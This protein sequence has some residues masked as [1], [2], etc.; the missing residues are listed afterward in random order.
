MKKFLSELP[1]YLALI[2]VVAMIVAIAI[3]G[4]KRYNEYL[5]EFENA[6]SELLLEIES[7]S[8]P[9]SDRA[10]YVVKCTNG[11]VYRT[12]VMAFDED[13]TEPTL[14]LEK[15]DEPINWFV[16]FVSGSFGSLPVIY[17]ATIY[18][19]R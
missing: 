15:I 14:L 13:V 9:N 8:L 6:P 7:I 5:D 4:P 18:L 1:G 11:G 2:M 17:K 3:L 12:G 10:Y 19:G 16:F